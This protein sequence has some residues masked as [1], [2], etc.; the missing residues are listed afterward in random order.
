MKP[1]YPRWDD[2]EM[3]SYWWL[4]PAYNT[5]GGEPMDEKKVTRAEV[6]VAMDL[7]RNLFETQ[8][9]GYYRDRVLDRLF[10]NS[11]YEKALADMSS[12]GVNCPEYRHVWN[13]AIEACI[14]ITYG[15][16]A[17]GKIDDLKVPK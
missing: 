17:C 16:P 9:A 12:M 2:P 6:M 5:K 11:K 14:N 13:A 10:P 15:T 4:K 3:K 1:V 8:P 7:E